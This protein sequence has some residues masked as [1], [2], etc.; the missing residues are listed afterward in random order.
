MVEVALA[1]FNLA[2]DPP[3]RDIKVVTPSERVA[4]EPPHPSPSVTPSPQAEK[5]VQGGGIV[6]PSV[7]GEHAQDEG[8]GVA[9]DDQA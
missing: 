3:D 9:S 8:A 5:A 2:M 1:A 6:A 7:E 4:C